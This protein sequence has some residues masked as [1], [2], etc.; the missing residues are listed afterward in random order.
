MIALGASA[1][2]VEALTVV[3]AGLPAD[4]TVPVIV[5][6]HLSA[7]SHSVLPQ[8]LDRRC[9]LPVLAATSSQRPLPGHVYV[10]PP[11]HHLLVRPE[12]LELDDGPAVGGHRPSLDVTFSSLADAHGTQ[13]I[14]VVLS[15]AGADG[16]AGLA[17]VAAAGGR[18]LVQD[19]AGAQYDAMPRHALEA[20]AGA[21]VVALEDLGARLGELTA[22]RGQRVTR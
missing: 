21:E 19:P 13:A 16:S 17:G 1:G 5:V 15:G 14:A 18:T 2:G 6:L 22:D 10:A 8:L 7:D 3:A 20:V 11:D 4:L 9:A 12:S